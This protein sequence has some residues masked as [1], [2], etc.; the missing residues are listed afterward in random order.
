MRKMSRPVLRYFGALYDGGALAGCSDSQL[1]ERIIATNRGADRTVAELAFASLAERHGRMVWHVLQSRPGRARRRLRERLSRHDTA[2]PALTSTH[3]LQ[4]DTWFNPTMLGNPPRALVRRTC[5]M[6]LGWVD[7]HAALNACVSNSIWGLTSKGSRLTGYSKLSRIAALLIIS[8]I[9]SG[10]I[11][12]QSRTSAGPD[13]NKNPQTTK[14][15]HRL[16]SN[17]QVT[18]LP[19]VNLPMTPAPVELNAATGR[20]KARVYAL[21]VAGKRLAALPGDPSSTLPEEKLDVR[22]AVVTGVVDHLAITMSFSHGDDLAVPPAERSYRRVELER[23]NQERG[24][25]SE[26][27]AVDTDLRYR[28]LD[29]LP[30]RV[31]ERTDEF[32]FDNLV[33]PVPVLVEGI[34][35]GLDVE[36][37]VP[38]VRNGKLVDP[39]SQF[40]QPKKLDRAGRPS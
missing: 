35:T 18:T 31:V 5:H 39:L 7:H 2:V 24:S 11:V 37:L 6:A 4:G 20:G 27:R 36:R 10:A 25:W 26:W 22:W 3:G 9:S 28:I 19:A 16:I 29:N 38:H 13:S 8:M 33:D 30:E 15:S 34:W 23:Q 21:D 17:G 32:R 12:L 40:G 14:D 1:L